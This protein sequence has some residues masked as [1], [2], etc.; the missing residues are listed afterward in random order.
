MCFAIP[1]VV[2]CGF[3]WALGTLMCAADLNIGEI[4]SHGPWYSSNSW[5]T[6]LNLLTPVPVCCSTVLWDLWC[7]FPINFLLS[8]FSNFLLVSLSLTKDAAVFGFHPSRVTRQEMAYCMSHHMS[9]NSFLTFSGAKSLKCPVLPMQSNMKEKSPNVKN[10]L[11][12]FFHACTIRVYSRW[13]HNGVNI[14]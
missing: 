4:C 14:V 9:R 8:K 6:A 1:T 11:M 10:E 12:F 7:H 2:S 3:C 5:V 13:F